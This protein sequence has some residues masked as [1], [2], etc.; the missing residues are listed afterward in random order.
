VKALSIHNPWAWLIVSGY[1]DI[2]NRDWPTKFRGRFLIHASKKMT[3]YDYDDAMD[4]LDQTLP[5]SRVEQVCRRAKFINSDNH[6]GGIIGEAEIVDCVTQSDSRWFFGK[7][8]FVITN[9]RPL[10]F[11]ACRGMLGFFDPGKIP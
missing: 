2:E 9:A 11:R 7:F 6:L 8:G 3:N 5:L 4:L 1:K 10:P